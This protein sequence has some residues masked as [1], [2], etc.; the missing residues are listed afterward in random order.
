MKVTS[1]T[2]DYTL[3]WVYLKNRLVFTLPNTNTDFSA[4]NKY[5]IT[6]KNGSTTIYLGK[7]IVVTEL[8][9]IQNYTP[10]NQTTQRY[11]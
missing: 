10:S 9:D 5:Q 7:M 8:T 4:G 1:N 6:I 11:K 2:K 3:T